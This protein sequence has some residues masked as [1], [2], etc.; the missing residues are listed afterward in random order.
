VISGCSACLR[1]ACRSAAEL[2]SDRA[3]LVGELAQARKECEQAGEELR[4]MDHTERSG[5][6]ETDRG[7]YRQR[8]LGSAAEEAASSSLQLCRTALCSTLQHVT[9]RY[10]TLLHSAALCS[11]LLHVTARYCTLQHSTARYGTLLHVTA[12]CS[13]LLHFT[14]LCSTT[15][16]LWLRVGPLT[17]S[18]Q[19]GVPT[20]HCVHG[21]LAC[22]YRAG[23]S[24]ADQA[25]IKA[26]GQSRLVT[27]EQPQP[28]PAPS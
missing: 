13:T 11:T 5:A 15:Y 1:G 3:G 17:S 6:P 24:E 23:S 18:S 21:W 22:M 28:P 7:A 26:A 9:A 25:M 16:T 2:A 8:S 27:P 20:L 19:S 4:Q 10:C 12:L 14:A